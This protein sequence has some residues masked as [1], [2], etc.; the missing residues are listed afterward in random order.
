MIGGSKERKK[1]RLNLV[2]QRY[3][4]L[5]VPIYLNNLI[6]QFIFYICVFVSYQLPRKTRS[7]SQSTVTMANSSKGSI[8]T[9]EVSAAAD[10]HRMTKSDSSSGYNPNLLSQALPPIG[11]PTTKIDAQPDLRSQT[12]RQLQSCKCS[13][14]FNCTRNANLIFHFTDHFMQASHQFLVVKARTRSMK[15]F[16][17]LWALG[18]M[19]KLASRFELAPPFLRLQSQWKCYNF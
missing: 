8:S 9:G 4:T 5:P 14:G 19:C 11:T 15:M 10:G 1:S 6:L 18:A 13:Y 7:A 2:L 12:N 17:H 16:R 3:I